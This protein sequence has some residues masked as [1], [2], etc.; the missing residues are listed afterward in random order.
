MIGVKRHGLCVNRLPRHGSGQTLP[1]FDARQWG[2]NGGHK[3]GVG[4]G[5]P[6]TV[7]SCAYNKGSTVRYGTA[8]VLVPCHLEWNLISEGRA[9]APVVIYLMQ[10]VRTAA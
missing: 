4:G 7:I 2:N 8:V 3:R 10:W 5:S 9:G 1:V 6:G